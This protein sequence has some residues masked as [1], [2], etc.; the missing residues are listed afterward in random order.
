MARTGKEISKVSAYTVPLPVAI[1]AATAA[2][3]QALVKESVPGNTRA[4]LAS[5]LRYWEAWHLAR[6]GE[7]LPLPSEP[8]PLATVLTYIADHTVL[9]SADGRQVFNM[10]AKVERTLL[11]CGAKRRKGPPRFATWSQRLSMLS[12]AHGM[13]G[14]PN[15]CR[16]AAVSDLVRLAK[17]PAE[18]HGLLP[19]RHPPAMREAIEAMLD[20]CDD[21]PTGVRDRALLLFAFASG[22]RRRSEVAG[23][24]FQQLE[25]RVDPDGAIYFLYYLT[26]AK[27]QA[28]GERRPK[29]VRGRAA[30]ALEAWVAILQAAKKPQDGPIF[31]PVRGLKK[32]WIGDKLSGHA[33]NDILKGRA[34]QA[35]L[36][37]ALTAHSL[38]GGF[39][40][41]AHRDGLDVLDAMALSDHRDFK[42]VKD[43][44][45]GEIE[46][47]NNPTG[48]LMP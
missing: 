11:A 2:V 21:S 30:R 1:D 29:P 6:Y 15:P 7:P 31:R 32:V 16:E 9:K 13:I 26:G 47:E 12:R 37:P 35:G 48:T 20:V 36:D 42:T 28:A 14:L 39:I 18:E 25:H 5:A 27:R 19:Q 45:L 46:V 44:Y 8:V 17:T 40:T 41:Q 34:T 3:L 22:G 23:A 38:R 24:I 10:P 43:H 33:I 4:A